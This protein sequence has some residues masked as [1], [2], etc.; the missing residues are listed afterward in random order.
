MTTLFQTNNS[1]APRKGHLTFRVVNNSAAVMLSQVVYRLLAFLTGILIIRALPSEAYGQYS[2]IYVYLSFFEIFVQFGLN[3]VLT[4]LVAQDEVLA[5]RILGNAVL[6]RIF[7]CG[8]VLPIAYILIGFL[9]YPLS[10]R[11]GVYL[12]SFQLFL[13]VRTVYDVIFQASLRMSYSA[14]WHCLKGLLQLIFVALVSFWK[15][16]LMM[17]VLASLASGYVGFLAYAVYSKRFMRLDFRLDS[18]LLKKLARESFPLLLSGCLTLLYFRADVFMLSKMKGFL[19]V[20]YYSVA[21]RLSESL[22]FF[23]AAV[24]VSIFPVLARTFK[25]NRLD[26]ERTVRK[27]FNVMLLASLPMLVGGSLAARDLIVLLFGNKYLPAIATF[28]LLLWYTVFGY[29]G[30]LLANILI[31]CGK[32]AVDA[33]ISFFLVLINIGLNFILIPALGFNGAAVSTVV[34]QVVNVVAVM[35]YGACHRDIRMP[36][37]WKDIAAA[38]MMNLFF[39]A[40]LTGLRLWVSL[41]VFVFIPLGALIYAALLLIFGFLK[42]QGILNYLDHLRS[43]SS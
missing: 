43:S 41:P 34:V 22:D 39:L 21:V 3:S 38:I 26:F 28:T 13:A 29:L 31:A 9:H 4:R 24:L 42:V 16:S 7:L 11:Q 37:P 36:I 1:G 14:V 15:P 30:Q 32:Q 5:P 23:P 40:L 6:L 8:V 17:F 25:E 27:G 20:G 33:W 19:E 10:V 12:A 2:F 35:T 18:A